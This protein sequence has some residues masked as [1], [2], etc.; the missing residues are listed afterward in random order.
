[1]KHRPPPWSAVYV[2]SGDWHIEGPAGED[3]ATVWNAGTDEMV[4]ANAYL[5]AAAPE[6]LQRLERLAAR[7]RAAEKL[8]KT[9]AD[10]RLLEETEDALP[11]ALE[12]LRRLEDVG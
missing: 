9:P 11:L 4:R 5:L 10:Y 1:M 7:A 3:I 8:Q 2:G 12:L 6:L